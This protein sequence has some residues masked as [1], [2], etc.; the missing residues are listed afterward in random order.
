MKFKYLAIILIILNIFQVNI[1]AQEDTDGE[2][3]KVGVYDYRPYNYIC[4]DGKVKG[5]YTD[6]LNLLNIDGKFK[7]EY[8]ACDFAEGLDKLEEGE[9]DLMMG[10][11]VTP[12]RKDRFVFNKYVV[13]TEKHG[14]YTNKDIEYGDIEKLDGKRIGLVEGGASSKWILDFLHNRNIDVEPIMHDNFHEIE[15]LLEKDEVEMIIGNMD[16]SNRYDLVYEFTAYQVHIA[17]NKN[18]QYLID[19]LDSSIEKFIGIKNNDIEKLSLKY[20]GEN[21]I[22]DYI[23][24]NSKL[25]LISIV[26]TLVSIFFIIPKVKLTIKKRKIRNRMNNNQYLLYYQP[27]HLPINKEIRAFEGLLRLKDS[28]G[29]IISPYKFIPEIENSG[30]LYEVSLWILNKIINDYK[31]IKKSSKFK[32]IEFYLSMNVSLNEL[33]NE[34]FV[35]KAISILEKSK[36][37]KGKICL[38]IVENVKLENLENLSVLIAS[39]KNA[40]FRIAIDD[41]GVEYSNLDILKKLD[42]DI[43][44]LDKYFIEDACNCNIK[45][46]IIL[47]IYRVARR[48][49]KSLVIEGVEDESQN[50]LIK[51]IYY[52]RLYVQGYLY[53][54]PMP[55]ECILDM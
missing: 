31:I 20:F 27:I 23:K 37:G 8:V 26:I 39:L 13:A 2:L 25:V 18:K 15:K 42:F 44:K 30:M 47:F 10:V 7:Y 17:A 9:I 11:A 28:N 32:D 24:H 14:I 46:E 34:E 50:E 21:D 48:N 29:K 43:V 36:I 49:N 19:E 3:V 22:F 51:S 35:K 12:E 5:Y 16:T 52:D 41:F 6:L 1:F 40:G 33:E 55:I 38:E 4:E 54:Q 53:N 45:E